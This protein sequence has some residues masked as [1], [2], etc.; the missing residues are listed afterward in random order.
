MEND[1]QSNKQ[2]EKSAAM[3]AIQGF[4]DIL[5]NCKALGVMPPA[6]LIGQ[7]FELVYLYGDN[8]LL[9]KLKELNNLAEEVAEIAANKIFPKNIVDLLD[10][11]PIAA[12]DMLLYSD[13]LGKITKEVMEKF[14][15]ELGYDPH[16]N[17]KGAI[18][19]NDL[20]NLYE[21][22]S[23]NRK[24]E[25]RENLFSSLHAK[26]MPLHQMVMQKQSLNNE[27]TARKTN[28]ER[29]M[30]SICENELVNQHYQKLAQ[31]LEQEKGRKIASTEL[32]ERKGAEMFA[33]Y[34]Q[35]LEKMKE[36][37]KE[38]KK[39]Q[40]LFQETSNIMDQRAQV[41]ADK[42]AREVDAEKL[43]NKTD[44]KETKVENNAG[45][46]DKSANKTEQYNKC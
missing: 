11:D 46:K 27:Q 42:K 5:K 41:Q 40:E 28:L 29:A 24:T 4:I 7:A 14:A 43:S 22:I 36:A 16:G 37:K 6:G 8:D 2:A 19:N 32:A 23:S 12:V 3:L 26:W 17:S 21:D 44:I 45:D 1:E 35:V 31:E 15:A 18:T 13:K 25:A 34:T 9:K 33:Q 38:P 20:A 10:K 39:I 30:L